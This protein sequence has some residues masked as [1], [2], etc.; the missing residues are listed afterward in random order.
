MCIIPFSD[1]S[2]FRAAEFARHFQTT[3]QRSG[4]L[5]NFS[6]SGATISWAIGT[7][8]IVLGRMPTPIPDLQV[9]ENQHVPV[10]PNWRHDLSHHRTHWIV[11]VNDPA[12]STIEGAR[13]LTQVTHSILATHA[14]AVGVLWGSHAQMSSSKNFQQLAPGLNVGVDPTIL[15]IA[16]RVARQ[17]AG[18]A[19]PRSVGMTR[20]L[21]DLELMDFE[22]P[23]AAES[24]EALQERLL[25]LSEYLLAHGLVIKDGDSVGHDANERIRVTYAD[26]SFGSAQRVLRLDYDA[27]PQGWEQNVVGGV[28]TGAPTYRGPRI[29]ALGL[30]SLLLAMISPTCLCC[31]NLTP[32]LALGAVILG[33]ASLIAIGRSQG[34]LM[35]RGLALTGLCLGYVALLGSSALQIWL[36]SIQ[37][38]ATAEGGPSRVAV[39]EAPAERAEEESSVAIDVGKPAAPPAT[40]PNSPPPTPPSPARDDAFAPP[41]LDP[42][43]TNSD[44]AAPPSSEAAP[45]PRTKTKQESVQPVDDPHL[46][47]RIPK[48]DWNVTALNFS[49]DNRWLAVGSIDT[50]I[51]IFEAATGELLYA[52]ERNQ[53]LSNVTALA[54]S[55]DQL[56]LYAGGSSGKLQAFSV[57]EQGALSAPREL[58]GHERS[59]T[60]VAVDAQDRFIASAG[61]DGAAVWQP[62]AAPERARR[63]KV[64]ARDAACVRL[65]GSPVQ[66]LVS[67]GKSVV[68]VDL[69]KAASLSTTEIGTSRG[70]AVDV[71]A[72][73]QL[74][75]I[76][77]G[78]DIR[79]VSVETGVELHKLHGGETQW[80]V[81]FSPDARLLLSGGRGKF[82]VWS[83]ATG[84]LV[85]TVSLN[86]PLYVQ[87]LAMS[88]DSQRIA[89]IPSAAGQSLCIF[90]TPRP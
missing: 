44:S 86:Q 84:E 36:W 54:F 77:H 55:K 83:T 10:W 53:T 49:P 35:G 14:T 66:A 4:R 82:K 22:A 19:G 47:V 3:W 26:S 13:L 24:A 45:V 43:R 69:W 80:C 48:I 40:S 37:N 76:A 62:P 64:F 87:V 33:H 74:A 41:T 42:F 88:A 23:R 79:I 18:P 16:I 61:A 28:A 56:T 65:V 34:R 75:A 58:A 25:E 15:W 20:G 89:A 17:E 32:I 78:Y 63:L 50:T 2:P 1:E 57:S 71:S 46:A 8:S 12:L 27:P 29:S 11:T 85:A 31:F 5:G 70:N 9:S 67:D 72:D 39:A 81:Q 51:R 30:F 52:G 21:S 90:R 59:V 6:N 73:G 60:G 38:N 7:S 68:G